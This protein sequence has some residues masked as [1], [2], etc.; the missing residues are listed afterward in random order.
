MKKK[1]MGGTAFVFAAA[2]LY[3]AM[4]AA[5]LLLPGL[6]TLYLCYAAGACLVAAGIIMIVRYF[7]AESF[8][9]LDHYGFSVGVFS[10]V[11]GLCIL[12]KSEE[13]S[14]NLMPFLGVALLFTATIK[15][16]NALDLQKLAFRFWMAVMVSALLLMICAVVVVIGPFQ[17]PETVRVFTG[18]VFVVDGALGIL[19]LFLLIYTLKHFESHNGKLKD[20]AKRAARGTGRLFE[21]LRGGKGTGEAKESFDKSEGEGSY[22]E[23]PTIKHQ[24]ETSH[25]TPSQTREPRR[26]QP[27]MKEPKGTDS[28]KNDDTASQNT[29]FQKPDLDK[30]EEERNRLP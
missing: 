12:I 11:V 3:L 7:V 24:T 29:A 2:F 23:N 1:Q 25:T 9:D 16:Q 18:V 22:K 21:S 10:V 6:K 20:T 30:T 27:Q 4:G 14:S 26:E 8:R 13:M 19:D 28:Q 5:F 15:L 17:S